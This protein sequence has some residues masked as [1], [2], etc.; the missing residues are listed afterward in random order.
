M[1]TA[2]Q[3]GLVWTEPALDRFLADP[4]AVAPRTDMTYA[5]LRS[6]EDRRALI[7]YLKN[8]PAGR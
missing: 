5:S 7:A 3:E 4:E 2:G 6:A 1:R 8:R